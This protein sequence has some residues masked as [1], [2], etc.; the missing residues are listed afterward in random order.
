MPR[1]SVFFLLV[2]VAWFC[3]FRFL[4]CILMQVLILRL[5]WTMLCWLL[6]GAKSPKKTPF[7]LVR[8][9]YSPPFSTTGGQH[10]NAY[11]NDHLSVISWRVRGS[12]WIFQPHSTAVNTQMLCVEAYQS[13]FRMIFPKNLQDV[14]GHILWKQ[15]SDVFSIGSSKI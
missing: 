12:P 2:V 3:V 4:I 6:F 10:P 1:E 15:E 11:H 8:I 13:Q 9:S 5:R 7:A 14:I